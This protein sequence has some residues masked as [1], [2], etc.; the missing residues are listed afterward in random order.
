MSNFGL[1]ILIESMGDRSL[2]A[3]D[4]EYR[5]AWCTNAAS[6][7]GAGLF[8]EAL[9]ILPTEIAVTV[10]FV[11][12]TSTIGGQSFTL[13]GA[14]TAVGSR[15]YRTQSDKISTL[16]TTLTATT[17]TIAFNNDDETADTT[18]AGTTV[19]IGREAILVGTHAGAGSYTGCVRGTLSTTATKH[20]KTVT[21][22]KEVFNA[23]HGP[24]LVDR[25]VELVRYPLDDWT[26]RET[27]WLGVLRDITAPEGH[28]ISIS[29]DSTL[30][31]LQ[32]RT[33]CTHLFRADADFTETSAQGTHQPSP[34]VARQGSSNN[35]MLV[36]I[37]GKAAATV[38]YFEFAGLDFYQVRE[39]AGNA[40]RDSAEI[41]E[42]PTGEIWEFFSTAPDAPDLNAAGD[43]LGMMA[44][45]DSPSGITAILQ[46]LTTT[47]QGNN[48]AYDIGGDQDILGETIGAGIPV[49]LIDIEAIEAVR[50]QLAGDDIQES[51]MLAFDGQPVNV[52]EWI[53]SI[54]IGFSAVLTIGDQAKITIV[55]LQDWPEADTPSV[56]EKD[57]VGAIQQRRALTTPVD[58]LEVEY[59]DR[60]GKG[61]IRNTY[62]DALHFERLF[63]GS[64]NRR[65][66]TMHGMTDKAIVLKIAS[67]YLERHRHPMPMM[68]CKL[69]R[70]RD[71]WPGQIL[72]VTH[73][74]IFNTDGS[75]GV[76]DG[77]FLVTARR[78]VLGESAIWY[79]LIRMDLGRIGLISP[80]GFASSYS[81]G[82][83]GGPFVITWETTF[84]LGVELFVPGDDVQSLNSDMTVSSFVGPA[85]V[86]AVTATTMTVDVDMGVVFGEFI[87]LMDYDEADDSSV[88][89]HDWAWIADSDGTLG[90]AEDDA[91]TW[92]MT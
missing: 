6:N 42:K 57:F 28:T 19:I 33:I 70:D 31:L 60:P 62:R 22:D 32:R 43:R 46:I 91:F 41:P 16:D 84:D 76:T 55:R 72:K 24:L 82:G 86:L 79:D 49:D 25:G 40:L 4:S 26:A 88:G 52:Y 7:M 5:Y 71:Y 73:P 38:K 45:D 85:T 77:V 23:D 90:T 20:G 14:N 92:V 51:L 11:A 75:R 27:L 29:A 64:R 30:A 59:W 10:D 69:L 80:S 17:T 74:Y 9:K 67:A 35:R 36:S 12:S 48:G 34:P 68:R 47:V 66:I 58:S 37:E 83:G 78:S 89:R 50:E 18:L 44:G 15:L 63:A 65:T 21:D 2:T 87:T 3:P 8:F 81:N 53:S 54:L 61:P 13:D 1:A 39:Y 56:T